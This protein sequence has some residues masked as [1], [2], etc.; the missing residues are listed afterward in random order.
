MSNS[1][2][3]H[4]TPPEVSSLIEAKLL[5]V[6]PSLSGTVKVAWYLTLLYAIAV[7]YRAVIRK[8]ATLQG[9]NDTLLAELKRIREIAKALHHFAG[10]LAIS[11]EED[12]DAYLDRERKSNEHDEAHLVD[13]LAALHQAYNRPL[14]KRLQQAGCSKSISEKFVD[15]VLDL[16]WEMETFTQNMEKLMSLPGDDEASVVR[17]LKE[18]AHPWRAINFHLHYH[19]GDFEGSYSGLYNPGVLGWS[20]AIMSEITPTEEAETSNEQLEKEPHKADQADR[21]IS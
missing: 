12:L 8:M 9:D 15:D 5:L 18:I 14:C 1:D 17:L 6:M 2:P 16:L 11:Y 4:L 19:L 3:D 7:A 13:D 21:D 20:L 10:L